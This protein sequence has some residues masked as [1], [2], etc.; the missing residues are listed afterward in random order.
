MIYLHVYDN[1]DE[2]Y[3]LPIHIHPVCEQM[4]SLV[5]AVIFCF[6]FGFFPSR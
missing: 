4:F 1:R 3:I 6:V 2:Y 5:E